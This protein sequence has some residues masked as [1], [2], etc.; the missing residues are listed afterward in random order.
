MAARA[1]PTERRRAGNIPTIY[2]ARRSGENGPHADEPAAFYL[3]L[4]PARTEAPKPLDFS[5]RLPLFLGLLGTQIVVQADHIL[6]QGKRRHY[7]ID[8]NQRITDQEGRR[9]I[10]DVEPFQAPMGAMLKASIDTFVKLVGHR[11]IDVSF[12]ASAVLVLSDDVTH[13]DRIHAAPPE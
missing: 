8:F 6:V 1:G 13:A 12:L 4:C 3:T 9:W 7:R 2:L 10:I 11:E 5:K